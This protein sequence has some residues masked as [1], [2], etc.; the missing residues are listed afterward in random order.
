VASR[1]TSGASSSGTFLR[2]PINPNASK[3]TRLD[4]GVDIVS[5]SPFLAVAGGTVVHIDPNFWNGTPAVYVKLDHPV[6]VNGRTYGAV[7]YSETKALVHVGQHLNA[8][9]PITD[10]GAGELGFAARFGGSWL[11]AAHG[12]YTEGVPTQQGKD[13]YAAMLSSVYSGAG[14]KTP[15]VTKTIV[16]TQTGETTTTSGPGAGFFSFLDN[17]LDPAFWLRVVEVMGGGFLILLGLYLL[18]RQVGLA[19]SP[20]PPVAGPAARAGADVADTFVHPAGQASGSRPGK[21]SSVA[22]HEVS[23]AA[24]RRAARKRLTEKGG[25]SDEIPF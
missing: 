18:A 24:D 19:T 5:S 4:Q 23:E 8:G 22:R 17:I 11:P 13:F 20:P 2:S 12:S 15:G 9:D 21:R 14:E 25:P 6:T 1:P 3:V 10:Q 16:N 7:Y